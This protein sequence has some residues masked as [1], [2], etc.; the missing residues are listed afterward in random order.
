MENWEIKRLEIGMSITVI[1]SEKMK[2]NKQKK[3]DIC[4]KNEDKRKK[5]FAK[6][7]KKLQPGRVHIVQNGIGKETS[8]P[9]RIRTHNTQ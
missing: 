7:M 9:T 3:E 8:V 6:R 4:K 1:S 2:S 5:I